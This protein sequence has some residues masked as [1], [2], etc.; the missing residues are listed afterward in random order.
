MSSKYYLHDDDTASNSST[1]SAGLISYKESPTPNPTEFLTSRKTFTFQAPCST[2]TSVT[3]LDQR[4]SA[5]VDPSGFSSGYSS[6]EEGYGRKSS[7]THSAPTNNTTAATTNTSPA[8]TQS[9]GWMGHRDILT[10][11]VVRNILT[12][13][14]SE[15][16]SRT[17]DAQEAQN[18]KIKRELSDWLLNQLSG[19]VNSE[20]DEVMR[21]EL[22][23][24]LEDL[25]KKLL[26]RLEQERRGEERRDV[27]RTVGETLQEEG[28]GA[29]SITDVERIVQR[30]LSLHKADGIGLADY[31]LESSELKKSNKT[32]FFFLSILLK[33]LK[34]LQ[35]FM[36]KFIQCVC[37]VLT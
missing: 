1:G 37:T 25:E 30:A 20:G 9:K 28:V 5:Q 29:V 2:V 21:P 19:S 35:G 4:T 32:P 18:R 16:Q 8:Y 26:D 10:A 7:A 23:R 6:T 3:S 27:W 13:P 22:Q 33:L 36:R 17:L 31:A 34:L 15:Y 14:A 12:V 11:P 24:A